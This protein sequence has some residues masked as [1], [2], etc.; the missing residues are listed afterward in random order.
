[1]ST[2]VLDRDRFLCLT[3]FLVLPRPSHTSIFSSISSTGQHRSQWSSWRLYPY[4]Y[5]TVGLPTYN[6]KKSLTLNHPTTSTFRLLFFYFCLIFH[7]CVY[8]KD[9]KN[10][11]NRHFISG[12]RPSFSSTHLSLFPRP[13][14][15]QGRRG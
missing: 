15:L 13:T 6:D 2:P 7:S 12:H 11:S 8:V 4:S 9:V 3:E 10:S 1:M 14:Y 5:Q